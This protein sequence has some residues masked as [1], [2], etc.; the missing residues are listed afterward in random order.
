MRAYFICNNVLSACICPSFLRLVK[1][2]C[3]KV[4]QVL[5]YDRLVE[6]AELM[7]RV[8]VGQTS[9]CLCLGDEAGEIKVNSVEHT[10]IGDASLY[11]V[12]GRD[13]DTTRQAP[14]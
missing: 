11:H 1:L 3:A 7:V 8:L 9:Q 10:V 5:V 13:A 12:I 4:V 6:D 14:T 2:L